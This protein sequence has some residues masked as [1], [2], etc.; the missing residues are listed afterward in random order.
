MQEKEAELAKT[1]DL[2]NNFMSNCIRFRELLPG[3]LKR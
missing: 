3:R 2:G 1:S